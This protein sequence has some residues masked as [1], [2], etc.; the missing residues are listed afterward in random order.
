[1]TTPPL[2]DINP[3]HGPMQAEHIYKPDGSIDTRF[4]MFWFCQ[5]GDCDG[6][7]GPVEKYKPKATES[8]SV[9]MELFTEQESS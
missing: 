5:V 1:M 3:D 6:Y 8:L 9:Q 4:G 7:G 2:C